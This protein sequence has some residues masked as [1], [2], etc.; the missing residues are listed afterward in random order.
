MPLLN[1]LGLRSIHR[2]HDVLLAS[3]PGLESRSYA[4]RVGQRLPLHATSW[5]KVL[6]AAMPETELEDYLARAPRERFTPY[7]ITDGTAVLQEVERTRPDGLGR[8]QEERHL[9]IIGLARLVRDSSG[10]AV[11]ALN[12]ALPS[13]RFSEVTE[14]RI[15][16]ALDHAVACLAAQLAGRA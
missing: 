14:E 12:V 1:T 6:L 10:A 3:W 5:G 16:K 13:A 4:Y 9:G 11:G 15:V 8:S 2:P 7:T